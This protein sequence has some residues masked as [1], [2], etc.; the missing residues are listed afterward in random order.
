[1]KLEKCHRKGRC[2]TKPDRFLINSTL[3]LK[4]LKDSVDHPVFIIWPDEIRAKVAQN[5]D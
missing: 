1:M 3:K 4:G 2:F 5:K